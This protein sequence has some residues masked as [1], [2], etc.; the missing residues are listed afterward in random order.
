MGGSAAGIV[1]T[2]SGI[3]GTTLGSTGGE[4][5][6]LLTSNEMPTHQ[7]NL[8]YKVTGETG[9][10]TSNGQATSMDYLHLQKL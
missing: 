9:V 8:M 1:T 2:I 7:H 3:T 10:D 4:Q 6:H 5:S